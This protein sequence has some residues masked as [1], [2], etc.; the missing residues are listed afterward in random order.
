MKKNLRSRLA[1]FTLLELL[2]VIGIIGILVGIGTIAYSSAQ[3]RARDSR[4]RGDIGVVGKALEQ[5]YAENLSYPADTSC[6]G[7]ENY[8]AGSTPTDPETG[9]DYITAGDCEVAG[10]AFCI[11]AELEVAGSGNAYAKGGVQTAC[12]WDGGAGTRDYFCVQ[13]Q[14]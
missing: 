11:C 14:Q 3:Q 2:V 10:D 4:R 1:G 6:S 7:Y 5:Y 12:V 8:L 13:N 9:A